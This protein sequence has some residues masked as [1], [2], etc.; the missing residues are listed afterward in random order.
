MDEKRYLKKRGR[1]KT[2]DRQRTIEL[3]MMKYWQDGFDALSL[4]EMCTYTEVSKP[5]LYREFG[6]ED[7][8]L[9][10]VL[11]HYYDQIMKSYFAMLNEDRPFKETLNRLI[12]SI[13][14]SHD[15]PQGCLFVKMRTS[16]KR[17]GPLT[18]TRIEE[19]KEALR[20][21]YKKMY[22]R[23]LDRNEVQTE[24]DIELAAYFIDIQIMTLLNLM[25]SGEP[26]ERIKNQTLLAFESLINK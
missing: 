11:Q 21:S 3:A 18:T 22:L 15:T 8:F 23:A 5:G 25:A 7:G 9:A 6:G 20:S 13:T 17:F 4:N 16:S 1:P 19:M 26:I 14:T 10:T 12:E 2:F 24:I